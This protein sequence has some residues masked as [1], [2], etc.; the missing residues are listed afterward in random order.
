MSYS[1]PLLTQ[2]NRESTLPKNT[3]KEQEKK[4]QE[5]GQF[6]CEQC[7]NITKQPW[8]TI[9]VYNNFYTTAILLM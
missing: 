9:S 2:L 6:I 3:C 8:Y 7:T 4:D 1:N 5:I